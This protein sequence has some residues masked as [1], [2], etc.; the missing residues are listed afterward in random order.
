MNLVKKHK[1]KIEIIYYNREDGWHTSKVYKS[2]QYQLKPLTIIKECL[3]MFIL[4]FGGVVILQLIL[5]LKEGE[6]NFN[7]IKD[8][9][10]WIAYF[11]YI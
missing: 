11:L 7:L 10:S 1:K 3:F 4:T 5:W 6:L 9:F 8:Y 2:L